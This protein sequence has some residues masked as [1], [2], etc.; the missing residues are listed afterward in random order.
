MAVKAKKR[1]RIIGLIISCALVI[2]IV[3]TVIFFSKRNTEPPTHSDIT[4]SPTA[5][6][7][8]AIENTTPIAENTV[9]VAPWFDGTIESVIPL[10]FNGIERIG[11]GMGTYLYKL[12]EDSFFTVTMTQSDLTGGAQ[13]GSFTLYELDKTS[14]IAFWRIDATHTV[15]ISGSNVSKNTMQSFLD[16]LS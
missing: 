12:S 3:C 14:Y 5:H 2:L 1:S 11:D 10:E 6:N 9:S 7:T 15:S 16:T 13:I 8:P 4:S